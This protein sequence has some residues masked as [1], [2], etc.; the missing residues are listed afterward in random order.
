MSYG[1]GIKEGD[2]VY[3]S[4]TGAKRGTFRCYVDDIEA[5]VRWDSGES[6]VVFVSAIAKWP[7]GYS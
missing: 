4:Y 1:K 5:V 3:A 2:R 6:E 7:K